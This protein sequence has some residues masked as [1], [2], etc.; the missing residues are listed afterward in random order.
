MIPVIRLAGGPYDGTEIPR[1][2][3]APGRTPARIGRVMPVDDDLIRW[4]AVHGDPGHVMTRVAV[5]RP[6][7][8][9]IYAYAGR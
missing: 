2:W 3:G 5:Y 1:R 8:P 9:G 6:H 4:A 7:L